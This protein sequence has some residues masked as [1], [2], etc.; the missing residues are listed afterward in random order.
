MDRL[1]QLKFNPFDFD[2]NVTKS[3]HF[4]NYTA[5]N[6]DCLACNYYL[7]YDFAVQQK[8]LILNNY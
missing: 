8:V 7:P 2:Y 3:K 4:E 6:L 5:A 1:T